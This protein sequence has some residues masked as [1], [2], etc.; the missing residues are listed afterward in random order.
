MRQSTVA[1]A[2]VV[3]IGVPRSGEQHTPGDATGASW[4]R[5]LDPGQEWV[6]V[7]RWSSLSGPDAMSSSTSLPAPHAKSDR[8]S[9]EHECCDGEDVSTLL[10]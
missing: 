3:R 4:R 5:D 9:E 8:R 6:W 1:V 10:V 7:E 2:S